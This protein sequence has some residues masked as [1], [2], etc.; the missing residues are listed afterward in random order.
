MEGSGAGIDDELQAALVET[1]WDDA[2]SKAKSYSTLIFVSGA[3]AAGKVV[4]DK[5]CGEDEGA[6]ASCIGC[7]QC[8]MGILS[9]VFAIQFLVSYVCTQRALHG[10]PL[11]AEL[12]ARY[13]D[14]NDAQPVGCMCLDCA[15][16]TTAFEDMQ[17]IK[18]IVS[19]L[20]QPSRH[21][22]LTF[23]ACHQILIVWLFNF[24][25]IGLICICAGG[26][27]VAMAAVPGRGGDFTG[28]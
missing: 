27:A 1:N 20:A 3:V 25:L 16:G 28:P 4:L 8:I 21:R 6:L 2:V 13:G 22:P 23:A 11:T 9:T 18:N 15:D 10:C 17:F 7:A 12:P 26:M 19:R 5:V 24:V 14:I